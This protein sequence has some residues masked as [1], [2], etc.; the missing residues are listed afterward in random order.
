MMLS[1]RKYIG[2]EYEYQ[3]NAYDS[4]ALLCSGRSGGEA[5]CSYARTG[6]TKGIANT[7]YSLKGV[8]IVAVHYTNTQC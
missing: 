4:S 1:V 8:D 6:D 7:V 3:R 2:H 5:D